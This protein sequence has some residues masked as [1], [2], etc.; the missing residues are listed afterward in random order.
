MKAPRIILTSLLVLG[1][2]SLWY[3]QR[4]Y[5]RQAP[6]ATFPMSVGYDSASPN[7]QTYQ[8]LANVLGGYTGLPAGRATF[9]SGYTEARGFFIVGWSSHITDAQPNANGYLTTL[10][11]HALIHSSVG[12][13]LVVADCAYY[14]QYQ[15]NNGGSFYFVASFDPNGQAG[16]VSQNIDVY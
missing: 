12:A 2:V 7:A 3:I 11:V 4:A 8:G 1:S 6:P 10:M 16:L 14:E 15:V 9:F 5:S 13:D